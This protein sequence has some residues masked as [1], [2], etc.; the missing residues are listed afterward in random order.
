M[1]KLRITKVSDLQTE[2]ARKD[3]K[4]SRQY[5]TLYGF[6]T[7]N[8][9][10]GGFQRNVFQTHS[11]DGK[12]A[13]WKSA[14]YSTAKS[15]VGQDIVGDI[16]RMEVAP[17]DIN[18]RQATSFTAVVLKGETVAT[19]AKANGHVLASISTLAIEKEKV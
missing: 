15:L 6:D 17:Y 16:V 13:F 1:S 3:G 8:P 2:K 11:Q 7:E 19:V 5:Y 9:I 14:D 4:V 12:T 10:T 18:G